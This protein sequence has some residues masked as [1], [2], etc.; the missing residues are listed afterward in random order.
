MIYDSRSEDMD[1]KSVFAEIN[2]AVRLFCLLFLTASYILTDSFFGCLFALAYL[3]ALLYLSQLD[4]AVVTSAVKR[5]FPL[6]LFIT[7]LNSCF[8][9]PKTAFF[10]WWVIAP[11]L[12]G[13]VRGLMLG[14]KIT[15]IV[16]L[17]DIFNALTEPMELASTLAAVLR[18]LSLLGIAHEQISV[19]VSSAF[20]FLDLLKNKFSEISRLKKNTGSFR[21]EKQGRSDPGEKGRLLIPVLFE[22]FHAARDRAALFEARS[23]PEYLRNN[24]DFPKK[25]SMYDYCAVTVCAAFFALQLIV[26]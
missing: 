6:L 19:T 25:I 26:F 5:L 21:A 11:S 24:S 14:L 16:V 22:A 20:W 3:F 4:F 13:F 7:L 10:R 15:E 18:P 2:P 9:S 17:F 1:K 12:K 23:V 8:Y